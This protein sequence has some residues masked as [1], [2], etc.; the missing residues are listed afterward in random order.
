MRLF[1]GF[2]KVS[3]PS[4]EDK[5]AAELFLEKEVRHY[6]PSYA[7]SQDDESYPPSDQLLAI[8][9][10]AAEKA[11]GCREKAVHPRLNKEQELYLNTWPGEHYR[12]LTALMEIIQPALAIEIGT[13]QGLG[14]LSMKKGIPEKGKII[15]YDVIPFNEITDQVLHAD[16]FDTKLEQRIADLS[17]PLQAENE[18]DTLA[19]AEFIFVDAAKDGFMEQAFLDLFDRISFK[20]PPVILI[21]D[22]RFPVM[23]PVWR[24]I[25]H[26]KLDFTSFG[27][28]SG[29]GLVEWK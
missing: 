10:K 13:Y 24:K 2:K 4:S 8:G 27:H 3:G 11:A 6:F 26:P 22:I 16:D 25:Q 14:C 23:I 15:T 12:L 5:P 18:M 9:I 1:S 17:D 7:F 21:D 19:E 29:S 28:W 20:K